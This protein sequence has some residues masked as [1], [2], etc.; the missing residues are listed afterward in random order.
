MSIDY[1]VALKILSDM[2][3]GV[4]GLLLNDQAPVCNEALTP[5]F[6]TIFRTNVQAY[7]ET[8]LGCALAHLLDREIDVRLPYVNQGERAYNGRTLDERV[9][10]PFLQMNRIP[11]SKGP[12][13]ALF[14]RSVRFDASTR[15]GLRD[16][17]GYDAFLALVAD[18]EALSEDQ[19]ILDILRCLLYRFA[20]LR[21]AADVVL[22]RVQRLSLDQLSSLIDSLLVSPSGGRIPVIVVVSAFRTL[23]EFFGADWTIEYQGINVADSQTGAGGDI[24]VRRESNIVIAA[25]VTERPMDRG[26]VVQTFHTKIAPHG[27]EDYL[28]FVRLDSLEDGARQQ[29]KQYFAQGHEVNFL[30]IKDWVVM[31]LASMGVRGRGIYLS[32]LL[33]MI[34]D[35]SM[36]RSIKVAWNHGIA[37]LVD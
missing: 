6:D 26:R 17:T 12:F 24:T 23:N 1:E 35:P 32:R 14:R 9:I 2:F 37:A 21:E 5:H 7:R 25:E 34:D 27:I 11:C 15:E 4:E 30:A 22:S 16:K 33:E 19:E 36:P 8:L 20:K 28:F 10:N 29:A 3:A 13:L 31:L 18:L